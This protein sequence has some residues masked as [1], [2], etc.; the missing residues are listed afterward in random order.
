MR[1]GFI[2]AGKVGC[3][4]GAYFG[5]IHQ[6][7]GYASRTKESALEAA[8]LTS[9]RAYDDPV[10]LASDS[11]LL[12]ITTPDGAIASAWHELREGVGDVGALAGTIVCHCSGSLPSTVLDGADRAGA[13]AGS[14]HPLFAISSKQTPASELSSAFFTFEGTSRACAV[15]ESL[16][17]GLGNPHQRIA[18]DEKV[19]YHAAAVMASNHV[20]A[21][22]QL[23]C[24]EL[25]RCGF[26]YEGAA[27]ALA[28]LF[29]GNAA[30]AA[31]AGPLAALT[32]PAERGDAATVAAHLAALSGASLPACRALDAECWEM[33]RAR[34]GEAPSRAPAKN[35]EKG[36]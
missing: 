35:P 17:K 22:Y 19:R 6:V 24:E 36:C 15:L 9:S 23:A 16:A 32:G 14:F 28:P 11:D 29:L 4:L 3:S 33:A 18:T 7:V 2:G 1:I 25:E 21:L 5:R 10:A 27:A 31:A 8:R 26:S 30:H 34:R 20:C 13:E 12:F